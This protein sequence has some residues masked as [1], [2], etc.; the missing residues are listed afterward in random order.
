MLTIV[1]SDDTRRNYSLRD[2]LVEDL[3]TYDREAFD[4]ELA[5]LQ[6]CFSP[7]RTRVQRAFGILGFVRFLKG[8]YLVLITERK[9]V[10]KLF[11]H[12]FY[13][14]KDMQLVPLFRET[15]KQNRDDENRYLNYF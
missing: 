10:G 3:R 13:Q 7:L 2:I 14:V 11:R 9:R 4:R 6:V 15:T 5:D 12:S 8:Y 1:K